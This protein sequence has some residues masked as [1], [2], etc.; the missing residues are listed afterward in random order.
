RNVHVQSGKDGQAVTPDLQQF[1]SGGVA[2]REGLPTVAGGLAVV[3][4]RLAPPKGS[5]VESTQARPRPGDHPGLNV[6]GDDRHDLPSIEAGHRAVHGH[7]HLG[8]GVEKAAWDAV[9]GG[10]QLT[11]CVPYDG[12]GAFVVVYLSVRG[13]RDGDGVA[14]ETGALGAA[15]HPLNDGAGALNVAGGYAPGAG[16]FL[17]CGGLGAVGAGGV[18]CSSRLV[19]Y[20]WLLTHPLTQSILG[21]ARLGVKCYLA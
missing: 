9:V 17:T 7:I 20:D 4:S 18:H 11:V 19:A 2:N 8:N 14:G 10:D 15:V 16:G 12:V 1:T 3:T 6:V 5:E 13:G 21:Q